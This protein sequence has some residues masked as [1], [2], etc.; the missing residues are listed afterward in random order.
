VGAVSKL[1]WRLVPIHK[2]LQPPCGAKPTDSKI[3]LTASTATSQGTAA[4]T[5]A[6]TAAMALGLLP[7]SALYNDIEY[8]DPTNTGCRT[9]VLTYL[10]AYTRQLHA[11]G[12]LAGAYMNL[13][14]GAKNLADAYTSTSYA[15][16]D[17]L[18]IARYDA[19]TSL[20]GWAG[21]DDSKWAVHQRLKQY[22]GD[23]T[24]TYGGVSLAVDRDQVDGP[25]ATVA[26]AYK[27]TGSATVTARSGPTATSGTVT[28][29]APGA[30][31]SVVCQAPGAKVATTAVWD[32]LA[33]GS[34]VSDATVSTPS[35][36]TYSAPLPHCS[37]PWQ[38]NAAAGLKERSAPSTTS[39][40]LGTTPNGAL[41]WVT[42]QRAG[43]T[44]STTA[45]WD[46]LD[47][48][49]YVSDY[50]VKNPSNTTYSKPAPRC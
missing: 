39:S 40:I 25:V 10:S 4:A 23:V 49:R 20:S 35:T 41:A 47:D 50:Y 15:R 29:Y 45:V 27:V 3:S 1:G 44:I 24:Q 7:G 2:G 36:T 17:A 19:T 26:G 32:K 33:D 31:L 13:G 16:P 22:Q 34:Y 42:C 48:G 5:E 37:Y 43:T 30:A 38:V 6:I 11:A 12:Y 46:K 8:Y 18:W 14:N 21:V 28:S 9:A